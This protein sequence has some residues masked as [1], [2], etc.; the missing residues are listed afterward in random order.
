MSTSASVSVPQKWVPPA[1]RQEAIVARTGGPEPCAAGPLITSSVSAASVD[2][3]REFQ[4]DIRQTN[5]DWHLSLCRVTLD[6]GP[7]GVEEMPLVS[8]GD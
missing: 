5:V 4:E 7:I 2:E 3:D 8:P 1:R 6:G